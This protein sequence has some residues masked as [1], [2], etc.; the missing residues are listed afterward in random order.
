MVGPVRD[1]VRTLLNIRVERG[2]RSAGLKPGIG[3][4]ICCD[5]V[6]MTVQAGMSDSLWRWLTKLGWREITFRPDRR[7]Y[8]D[9]PTAYVTRLVD[10]TPEERERVLAAAIAN[11]AY[12]GRATRPGTWPTSNERR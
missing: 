11:A 7:R 1:R 10:S 12:R 2:L 3:A 5:D 6:R 8:R 4:R 9:I